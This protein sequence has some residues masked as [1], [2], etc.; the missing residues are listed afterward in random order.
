MAMDRSYQA[1][2]QVVDRAVCAELNSGRDHQRF[3]SGLA[4]DRGSVD[5]VQ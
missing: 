4:V 3:C 2:P 1:A 5:N